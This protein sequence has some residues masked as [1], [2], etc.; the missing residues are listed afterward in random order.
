M[1]MH[2]SCLAC[3]G[4]LISKS[5]SYSFTTCLEKMKAQPKPNRNFLPL[6]WKCC[7]L[8][9]PS[10]CGNR[11]LHGLLTGLSSKAAG[12]GTE[13]WKGEGEG[14]G[15]VQSIC[16][17]NTAEAG[18]ENLKST[19]HTSISVSAAGWRNTS[20]GFCGTQLEELLQDGWGM[21]REMKE[22]KEHLKS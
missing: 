4:R 12:N 5:S 3:K 13:L 10:R 16:V 15:T 17:K 21:S 22:L 19:F 7:F 14:L 1:E 9:S 8:L 6:P 20:T 11:D 2:F 18:T